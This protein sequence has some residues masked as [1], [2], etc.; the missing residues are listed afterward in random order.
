MNSIIV[1]VMLAYSSHGGQWIPTIEF[2]DEHKCKVAAIFIKEEL[3]NVRI[4]LQNLEQVLKDND[5][6]DDDDLHH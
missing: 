3:D 1:W 6:Y 2:K 4:Y 5:C